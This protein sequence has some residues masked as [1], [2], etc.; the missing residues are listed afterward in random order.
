MTELFPSPHDLSVHAFSL[1]SLV[2]SFIKHPSSWELAIPLFPQV[3]GFSGKRKGER[4]M[5]SLDGASVM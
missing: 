3:L 1:T 2:L 4:L 5:L